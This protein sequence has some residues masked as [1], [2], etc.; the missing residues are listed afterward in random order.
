MSLF[1]LVR[2][3]LSSIF[4]IWM[5]LPGFLL[6]QGAE[7]SKD[8]IIQRAWTAMFGNA[9]SEDIRSLYVESFFHGSATP[10]RQT[11]KRPNLF[12]NEVSSGV[13]VFDGKRAAWV[14]RGPDENGKR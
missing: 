12:R 8:E 3:A 9:R 7:P 14:E 1:Y 13:L 10:S 2:T 4:I 5:T 6:G 11:V